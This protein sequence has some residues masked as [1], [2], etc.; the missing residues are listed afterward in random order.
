MVP[1][2]KQTVVFA[3]Y[4]D[5]A[6]PGRARLEVARGQHGERQFAVATRE[7]VPL[8]LREGG[9]RMA[10]DVGLAGGLDRP[11]AVTDARASLDADGRP[12]RRQEPIPVIADDLVCCR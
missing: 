4:E 10:R 1:G 7:A 5:L 6:G 11:V 9:L 8:D 2:A 3:L 12:T